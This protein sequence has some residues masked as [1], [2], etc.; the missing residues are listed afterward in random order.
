MKKEFLKG[1]TMLL[2]IV[3]VAFVTAVASHAQVPHTASTDRSN[4]LMAVIPFE[5]TIDYKTM[6]AGEYLVQTLG[7]AGSGLLIQSIDGK[8]SAFRPSEAIEQGR[9]QANARLVFHRYG[10]RYFLSQVWCGGDSAGRQLMKSRDELDLEREV[11]S[12]NSK[13]EQAQSSYEIIE[14]AATKNLAK[15]R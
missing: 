15:L 8:T 5:F 4:N 7:T 10:E 2:G 1:L 6:P 11:A 3:A 12:I 9:N 14:V 13:S